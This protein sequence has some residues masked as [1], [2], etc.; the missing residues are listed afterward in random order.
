MNTIV[1]EVSNCRDLGIQLQNDGSFDIHIENLVK[2]VKRLTGWILRSFLNISVQFMKRMWISIIRPHLDYCS[3]LWAPKEGPK[4]DK[5]ERLQY[6]Y[7]GFI[8]EIR[9]LSY[10]ERLKKLKITSLQ[11]RYDRYR[12]FY[13]WKIANGIVPNCGIKQST[14]SD[15]RL[16]LKYEVPKIYRKD[17]DI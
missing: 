11:R 17:F 6:F 7:T 12:I 8:P 1:E 13:M 3:Q 16:G 2:K 5:V 4:M 9:N 10:E 15:S 14:G